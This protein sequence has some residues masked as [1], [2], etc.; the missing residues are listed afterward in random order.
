MCESGFTYI[1]V[2]CLC[3]SKPTCE[4]TLTCMSVWP[5]LSLRGGVSSI[6]MSKATQTLSFLLQNKAGRFSQVDAKKQINKKGGSPG[7]EYTQAAP[8]LRGAAV[9]VSTVPWGL[10]L[11]LSGANIC[12]QLG[13]VRNSFQRKPFSTCSLDAATIEDPS[14]H[15]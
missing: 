12:P 13:R 2:L 7:Y 9:A 11:A 14:C 3:V 8:L 15:G 1:P 4:H 5:L 10:S 6:S